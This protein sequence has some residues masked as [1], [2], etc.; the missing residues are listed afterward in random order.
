MEGL[1]DLA[2]YCSLRQRV[3]HSCITLQ[4]PHHSQQVDSLEIKANTDTALQPVHSLT[5]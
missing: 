2:S 5:L 3:M 4:P 1:A